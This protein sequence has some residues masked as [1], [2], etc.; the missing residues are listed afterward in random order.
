[1]LVYS[2][3]IAMKK[4]IEKQAVDFVVKYE[5]KQGRNP[6]VLKLGHGYDVL[7]SER[8]IEVKGHAPANPPFVTFSQYNFKALQK[9][10]NFYLYIV[11]NLKSKSPKLIILDKLTVLERAK[12]QTSWEVPIW[13]KDK[14]KSINL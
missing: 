7:S 12:I 3:R 2:E 4:S 1:M 14:V 6:E 8:K 11:Y 10:D 9:E 13:V 5:K